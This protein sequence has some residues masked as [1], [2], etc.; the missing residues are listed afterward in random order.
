MVRQG[1]V[2][3]A[4]FNRSNKALNI[5]LPFHT[6]R[7]KTTIKTLIDS[8]ATENFISPLLAIRL[9]V[10]TR[11]LPIPIDL[12]TVDGSTHQ[13]GQL[14]EYCWL[15][16]IHGQKE[17]VMFFFVATL[18]K[19]K[20][21]LGHPFLYEFNPH[22]DWRQGLIKGGDLK[23]QST[24]TEH[25][26]HEIFRL[27]RQAIK[28][29]GYPK[30]DE[31][32][33]VRRTNFAQQW[34]QQHNT[35][36]KLTMDTIPEKYRRHAMVFSEEA[37][38]RFPPKR[39]EDMTIKF[40]PDA[41]RVINCKVYPLSGTDRET[42][43]AWLEQEE[44]LKRIFK[45]ASPVTSP[46]FLIGKKDSKEKRVVMDFREVN[47]WTI[48]DNNPLPNIQ[49]A[50]E[51]LHGK[52]LFSKFDIRWGYNNIRIAEEDQHK[53]AFKTPFGTYIPRVMYFGLT[54]APPFF[55]R[56][57]HRD[58]ADLLQR[59][60]ENLG[61]Y[62]D[63][64]WVATEQDDKGRKLHEEIT[65]A[66]LDRMEECSYFLKPSKC[67]FEQ[68]Q[69]DILGWVVGQGQVR[70]DPTKMKGLAE[71]PRDL[72]TVHDVRQ[73]LGLLGYQ[74]PFIRGF[75]EIARPLTNLTKKS[76][77]FDWTPECREAL[78]KLIHSVTAGP[79]LWHPDPTKQYELYTDASSFA[80]GAVLT[81][82][83]E[84]Q[85][86]RVV[87]FH[88]KSL[89]AA[90]RNYSV[91]DRE[92]L[93][94]IEALK[95]C[96]HLV[97]DSQ[98]KIL[99]FTDH[100]NLR[101][102][103]HPQKI[104]RRVARYLGILADFNLEIRHIAGTKNWADPL[105]RR[106]DLKPEEGDN[107]DVVALPDAIFAKT[108]HITQEE[109]S[110]IKEQTDE[111]TLFA[112][113]QKK[114]NLVK[115]DEGTWRRNKAV[116][117]V[118]PTRHHKQLLENY[119]DSYT[120]G[121]PGV[122]KTLFALGTDFWWP[123]IR[124]D[125]K[126]Y[127]AGCATCQST[128]A[129]T[130]RNKPEV[131]PITPEHPEPFGTIAVDFI[132]KLPESRG[133][134]TILTITDHDCTKAVLLIPCVEGSPVEDIADAY[135]HQAFP[136]I[137]IPQKIIS[138]RDT[139]FTSRLF[140]EI[141]SQLKIKQNMS[142]AYHPQTDGQSERTNQTV[143]TILRVYCNH[144]QDNWSQHLPLVQY[145]INSR[146]ANA[147]KVAPFDAWMGHVPRAHQ[148]MHPSALPKF[149]DRK[150]ELLKTRLQIKTAID[151][152][153]ELMIKQRNFKPYEEGERVWLEGTNLRTTHPTAKLRARRFGPFSI[154]QKISE[155]AYELKL[156]PQWRI[157][158]VFHASQLHPYKETDIHGA[159]FTD[160]APELIEG[161]E[162]YEVESVQDVRRH[163]K[164][165]QLQ[166]LI[167]WKGYSDAHNSW[168]LRP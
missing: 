139:R 40:H 16:I 102:Y 154:I 135:Y 41:P 42:I 110:I 58:F 130:H 141:C 109:D 34:A 118:N 5:M 98:H 15:K 72:K 137:G 151:H 87:G 61:N 69:M 24:W 90:E 3:S 76:V 144:R 74:R 123:S 125:T 120:A 165:R 145:V 108:V 51:R 155:V 22:I 156:P 47:K 43:I 80:V 89:N 44:A 136:Y 77:K 59:Y 7:Q 114:Y 158:P 57:M 101:Y 127:V 48:R 159:N 65:H 83:D 13:D 117:V 142:T 18:G 122:H 95:W 92:F 36:P 11:K 94:I 124:Q 133:Y 38:K 152:A 12:R 116:V 148:T 23:I 160:P 115:D 1:T 35:A 32:I 64:W 163:G 17:E 19:D 31:A 2:R 88:S 104:N 91:G 39:T 140:K 164:A 138:D 55:Q 150:Q 149:E 33:Y 73:V 49:T 6:A 146:P 132:T 25:H 28:E 63:D 46:T 53:A 62:M 106:P 67:L 29:V 52:T 56:T 121:H 30:E 20:M 14:T 37:S 105:S 143:E 10:K 45:G 107:E 84:N 126:D 112:Q 147:T 50:L 99:L 153:Q 162:E 93:G 66:F 129:I 82:R 131:F 81:Q 70:I 103:R 96:R 100:D 9:G 27:Q 113:W 161:E 68:T 128:K 86:P 79:T 167:K 168:V 97:V 119:H 85:K 60:P 157:H 8:G 26:G 111:E 21:I 4:V 134:D 78:D 75:A 166:Y 54:N 71:W